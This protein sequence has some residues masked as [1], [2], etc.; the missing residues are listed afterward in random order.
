LVYSFGIHD[1]IEWET[2]IAQLFGC[3]VHAFDP[4]VDTT[5]KHWKKTKMHGVSFH[6][7]GLQGAGTDMSVTHGIQ[8]S[9]I[10]PNLLLPLEEIQKRLGHEKRSLDL[11]MLDC[12]GCKWGVLQQFTCN[13]HDDATVMNVKQL[14]VEMHFQKSLGMQ[15]D[16]NVLKASRA[17]TRLR[18]DGWGIVASSVSRVVWRTSSPC[19]CS[20]CMW[21]CN[22]N[23]SVSRRCR[24]YFC[25][26]PP[27][28]ASIGTPTFAP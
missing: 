9:A 13:D 5:T 24:I 14:V 1:S 19:P 4:T 15:S 27:F 12:E 10:D 2:K 6:K 8:Y 26:M 7:F 20:Y 25:R 22:V 16:A 3:K 28:M 21:P 11:L 18:R 23:Q 17:P